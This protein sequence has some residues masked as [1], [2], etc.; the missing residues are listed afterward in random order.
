MN[1]NE[2]LRELIADSAII[3]IEN[4]KGQSICNL[5]EE[6]SDYTLKMWHLPKDAFVVKCDRFPDTGDVFFRGKNMECKKADYVIISESKNVIM[7]FELARSSDTKTEKESIAQLKGAS[8][9]I[10]YCGHIAAS[11]FDSPDIFSGLERRYYIV[12]YSKSAKRTFE[13]LQTAGS[14]K[15]EDARKIGGTFVSFESL[16]L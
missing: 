3:P 13:Q 14:W 11:F 10:E 12:R 2:I 8:C 15:P 5:P 4:E 16:M 7:F 1:T 6:A 9:I